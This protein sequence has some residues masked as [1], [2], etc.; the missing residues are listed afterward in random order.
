MISTPPSIRS[1]TPAPSSP[2][3]AAAG[4]PGGDPRRPPGPAERRLQRGVGAIART[5]LVDGGTRAETDPRRMLDEADVER[6][7]AEQ[8]GAQRREPLQRDHDGGRY[9][10]PA[11]ASTRRIRSADCSGSRSSAARSIST[12]CSA[13]CGIERALSRPPTIRKCDWWPLR[14]A[15]KTTPVL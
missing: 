10:T 4:R 9:T 6:G 7:A 14:Y 1:C 2:A 3:G 5:E 8:A 13:R 11:T 12:N 15:A